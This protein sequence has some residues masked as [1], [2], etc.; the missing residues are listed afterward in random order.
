MRLGTIALLGLL[1]GSSCGGPA[2]DHDLVV[3]RRYESVDGD[4]PPSENLGLTYF[5]HHYH[6]LINEEL[7]TD[8]DPDRIVRV[9]IHELENA[10]A[11]DDG[12]HAPLGFDTDWY[13]WESDA[14]DPY[15]P[16]PDAEAEW[17][18]THAQKRVRAKDAWLEAPV[19]AAI[20]RLNDAAGA[21]V[22]V[23]EAQ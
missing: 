15:Y 13:L 7:A 9:I 17:L 18:A 3:V 16:F 4:P 11:I 2:D 12:G 8:E 1:L 20:H 5:L 19:A 23:E 21:D 6:C 14:R 22:F 10:L